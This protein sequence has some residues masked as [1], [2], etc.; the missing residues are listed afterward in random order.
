[1]IMGSFGRYLAETVHDHET[2]PPDALGAERLPGMVSR[3]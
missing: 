2:P 1:M 3:G